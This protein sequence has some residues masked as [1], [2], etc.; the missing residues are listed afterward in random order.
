MGGIYSQRRLTE[1][2]IPDLSNEIAAME[3]DVVLLVPV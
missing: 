3:P 1:E 2:L